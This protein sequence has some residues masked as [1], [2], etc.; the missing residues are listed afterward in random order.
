M[1]IL[2]L[3]K[4]VGIGTMMRLET[5]LSQMSVPKGTDEGA[6]TKW[7]WGESSVGR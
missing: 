6:E 4:L 1:A 5:I 3:G 7:L 2:P